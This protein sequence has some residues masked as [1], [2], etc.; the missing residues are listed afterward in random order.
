MDELSKKLEKDMIRQSA[1]IACRFDV[2][3]WTPAVTVGSGID[4]VWVYSMPDHATKF[5]FTLS[6]IDNRYNIS[7]SMSNKEITDDADI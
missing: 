5:R 2:G 6:K 4:T 1:V 7:S 3:R